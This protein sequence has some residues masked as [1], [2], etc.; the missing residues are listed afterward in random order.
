MNCRRDMRATMAEKRAFATSIVTSVPVGGVLNVGQCGAP[1]MRVFLAVAGGIDVPPVLGSRATFLLGGFGGVCGRAL[2]A[3]D[4]LNV[5]Q[6]DLERFRIS[7][8]QVGRQAGVIENLASVDLH[9]RRV[10]PFAVALVRISREIRHQH[11]DLEG[12]DPL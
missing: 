5:R 1:G 7:Q 12:M 9:Q 11:G 2:V 10:A 8:D 3:G 4:V 6:I